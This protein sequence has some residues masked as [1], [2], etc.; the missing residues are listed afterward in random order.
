[1]NAALAVAI[2]FPQ[3]I[4]HNL[5]HFE[6]GFFAS[7]GRGCRMFLL[8]SDI[9]CPATPLVCLRDLNRRTEESMKLID[10]S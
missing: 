5:G 7:A 4:F 9:W 3:V 10:L 8:A 2:F 1:M 6:R